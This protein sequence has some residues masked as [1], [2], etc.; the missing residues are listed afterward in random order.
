MTFTTGNVVVDSIISF[1]KLNNKDVFMKYSFLDEE[2]FTVWLSQQRSIDEQY[3]QCSVLPIR[4]DD[5]A[6]NYNNSGVVLSF[7]NYVQEGIKEYKI[8]A[9]NDAINWDLI[10]TV[11]VNNTGNYSIPLNIKITLGLLPFGLLFFVRK[12]K[13]FILLFPLCALFYISCKKE[14]QQITNKTLYKVFKVEAIDYQ[15]NIIDVQFKRI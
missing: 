8:S 5:V 10:Q 4:M 3:S 2:N 11:Q 7:N 12:K 9:S 13:H 6:I 15:N 14:T 1:K